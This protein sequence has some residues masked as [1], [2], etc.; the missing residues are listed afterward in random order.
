MDE[1]SNGYA[2]FLCL[3]GR[4]LRVHLK[5]TVL[6]MLGRQGLTELITITA[7]IFGVPHL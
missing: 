6:A 4:E 3:G 1:I 5:G 7:A 2:P